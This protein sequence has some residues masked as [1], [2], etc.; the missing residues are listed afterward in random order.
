MRARRGTKYSPLDQ[1]HAD[2]VK[3]LHVAWR[4]SSVDQELADADPD[5][6]FNPLLL[7]T[8]LMV[9]G[10]AASDEH[11]PGPGGGHRPPTGETTWVYRALEDGAG[12]PR[13]GATRSV[14]YWYEPERDDERA[15]P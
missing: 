1:V 11:Q 2:N 5:L 15:L 3:D 14:G 12:R 4:W 13:A 9:R 10:G 7:I 8:P 6:Q